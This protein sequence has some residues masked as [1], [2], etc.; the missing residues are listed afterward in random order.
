MLILGQE[1]TVKILE[2]IIILTVL[3]TLSLKYAK[4]PLC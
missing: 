2:I 4:I 3:Y 1:E